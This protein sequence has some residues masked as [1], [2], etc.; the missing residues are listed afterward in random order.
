MN[1]LKRDLEGGVDNQNREKYFF[2]FS[3]SSI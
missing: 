2:S 1:A 3:L